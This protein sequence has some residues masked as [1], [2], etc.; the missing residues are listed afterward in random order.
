MNKETS[1][2]KRIASE[3]QIPSP[4]K[5]L[6]NLNMSIK[7]PK[8]SVPNNNIPSAVKKIIQNQSF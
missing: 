8:S 5:P 7:R 2:L 3:K 4:E 1:P 6:I